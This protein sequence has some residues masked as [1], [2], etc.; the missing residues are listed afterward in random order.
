MLIME[1]KISVGSEEYNRRY[2]RLKFVIF[3]KCH[4]E[5]ENLNGD[6]YASGIA[7]KKFSVFENLYQHTKLI[8]I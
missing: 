3:E 8:D 5:D 6:R 4:F 2:R 7:L 1:P